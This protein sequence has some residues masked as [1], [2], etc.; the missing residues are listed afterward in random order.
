MD[1]C[2]LIR[3]YI[4]VLIRQ[5][6]DNRAEL[7]KVQLSY[8]HMVLDM[9][10]RLEQKQEKVRELKATYTE[11]KTAVAMGTSGGST[12]RIIPV[13]LLKQLEDQAGEKEADL[14]KVP[15]YYICIYA[16]MCIPKGAHIL[17]TYIHVCVCVC[18]CV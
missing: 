7:D 12:G 14:E 6:A 9:K 11:I 5:V 18:V 17:Y 2:V 15:S 10:T 8:D 3:H 1:I 16:Y 4:C 13:K